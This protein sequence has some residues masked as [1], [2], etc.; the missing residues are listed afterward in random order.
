M[1]IHRVRNARLNRS[2]SKSLNT[3]TARFDDSQLAPLV[4]VVA[5]LPSRIPL[6]RSLPS[7]NNKVSL[8]QVLNVDVSRGRT[9][10]FAFSMNH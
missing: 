8:D 3:H 4:L 10:C 5:H 7:A 6:A 1:N 9:I 2:E